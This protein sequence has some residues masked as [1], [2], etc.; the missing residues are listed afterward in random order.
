[1][2]GTA[3]ARVEVL[4][5]EVRVL[6]V[7]SRQVTMSV[8]NQLDTVD[9]DEIEPFGRVAPRDASITTVYVVGVST[10]KVD[11]GSLVRARHQKA[12]QLRHY[13]RWCDGRVKAG[14]AFL[15]AYEPHQ[16]LA[17]VTPTWSSGDNY[18]EW[19]QGRERL[20]ESQRVL[21]A[22][23][24]SALTGWRSRTDVEMAKE[25]LTPDTLE[26]K[27]EE[28]RQAELA[29]VRADQWEALPLIVLAGLR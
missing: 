29:A 21:R 1:M 20:E 16:R 15:A 17:E 14:H 23:A 28:G 6:M 12:E 3:S 4:T 24:Q 26:A 8:Y 7:G 11:R 2:T 5:A 13:A 25:A 19:R 9:A 18:E 10:R 22:L 27:A